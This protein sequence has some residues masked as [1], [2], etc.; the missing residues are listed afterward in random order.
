MSVTGGE[1]QLQFKRNVD[2]IGICTS[3]S[4]R[5]CRRESGA[6]PLVCQICEITLE[7]LCRSQN[8]YMVV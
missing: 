2:I 7:F 6:M 3:I 8:T 4:S 1:R 5:F